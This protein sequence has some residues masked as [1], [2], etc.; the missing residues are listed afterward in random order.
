MLSTATDLISTVTLAPRANS[1]VRF[2]DRGRQP[3]QVLEL[4]SGIG[5]WLD[6]DRRF[7]EQSVRLIRQHGVGEWAL[8]GGILR[9]DG[10]LS[11]GSPSAFA[12]REVCEIIA[13]SDGLRY[14]DD[15]GVQWGVLMP[16]VS[17]SNRVAW[18]GIAIGV[19]FPIALLDRKWRRKCLRIARAR[20][21]DLVRPGRVL[22]DK[23]QSARA[24]LSMIQRRLQLIDTAIRTI[25]KLYSAAQKHSS[26]KVRIDTRRLAAAAW[27]PESKWPAEWSETVFEAVAMLSTIRTQSLIIPKTGWDPQV[28][29]RQAAVLNVA[30]WNKQIIYVHMASQFVNFISHWLAHDVT[31]KL[32]LSPLTKDF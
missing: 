21:T 32:S 15:A 31:E 7:T 6:I 4:F 10:R 3:R 2:S 27:G 17:E 23:S 13:T 26:Q 11:F 30:W 22:D 29:D 5:D 18:Q 12:Y 19:D 25:P 24:R 14:S 28:C 20:L 16:R 9:P 1:I 8:A